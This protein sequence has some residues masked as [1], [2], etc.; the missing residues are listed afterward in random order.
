MLKCLLAFYRHT[1]CIYYLLLDE[2]E[3]MIGKHGIT[4]IT[5]D[6]LDWKDDFIPTNGIYMN[7]FGVQRKA[8]CGLDGGCGIFAVPSVLKLP[9]FTNNLRFEVTLSVW[10]KRSKRSSGG[11]PTIYS[12]G[13]CGNPASEVRKPFSCVT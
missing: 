3:R 8:K 9:F 10:F 12:Y 11:L 13:G 2:K 1:Y 4:C 6:L 7:N 5:F